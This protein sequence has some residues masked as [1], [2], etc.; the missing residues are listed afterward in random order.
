MA[1]YQASLLEMEQ[2]T[3]KLSRME[4]AMAQ[5]AA[6]IQRMTTQGP[7]VVPAAKPKQFERKQFRKEEPVNPRRNAPDQDQGGIIYAYVSESEVAALATVNAQ[8]MNQF[9]LEWKRGPT[10]D[11]TGA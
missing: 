1:N 8:N 6:I 5:I 11:R 3:E 10:K 7:P 2:L 9:V 4:E